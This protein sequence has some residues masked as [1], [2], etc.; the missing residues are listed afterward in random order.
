MKLKSKK[1]IL[2][3]LLLSFLLSFTVSAGLIVFNIPWNSLDYR[4]IDKLYRISLAN[5]KGPKA[6]D[7]IVYLNIDDKTYA[8][9]KT[10]YLNRGGLAKVN[11]ILAKIRPQTVFYD[12][13]FSRPSSS[14]DDTAFAASIKELGNVYLPAGFKLSEKKA[15]FRWESGVFFEKLFFDYAKKITETGKGT[16]L[17]AEWALPQH[18]SFAA[19]AFNS[20]H[21]S[22]TPD[23]DGVLRHF[24][25]I[26][27]IDSLYFPSAALSIFL[28]YNEIPFDK[29][30]I[31]W[32]ESLTIPALPE[33]YL[34]K[35]LVIP[36]DESGK[37]FVPY[38]SYWEDQKTKMI[39]VKKFLEYSEKPE[40]NDELLEYFEGSFVLISDVSVGSSDLGQ[41][42]LEENVPLISIHGALLNSLLTNN[43][44]KNWDKVAL[45]LLIFPF[46]LLIGLSTIT[47]SAIPM[48]LAGIL[49]ISACLLFGYYEMTNFILF[50]AI[51]GSGALFL[52]FIGTIVIQQIIVSKDQ[53]FIKNAF[54]KY[55][56]RKVV[57][58]LLDNPELLK[59]GG[60]ERVLSIL[61]ADIANF[62]SIS[63]TMQ[64]TELVSL[65]NEYL[66][67]MTD[68]ILSEGGTIDKYIGD[69]IL[70]E[71]GV[72]LKMD[73][74]AFA[75]VRT[76][77]M[78]QKRVNELYDG[79]REKNLPQVR[80]RIGINTGKVT[81]GNMG[82]NQVF[83]YTVIGDPVNLASRLESVNKR[84]RTQILISE[85]TLK[86]LPPDVFRTRLVDIIKV[87]GKTLA[88]KIYEVYGFA[89]EALTEED[90]NYYKAYEKGFG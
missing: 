37:A 6:S 62:T 46:G 13:I 3:I 79:S 83:D 29:I 64:S 88:V 76:A 86:E 77:L 85:F 36:I 10:N 61:F 15:L 25:L 53:A 40:Y 35:D 87:K 58:Q 66:T 11:N 90:D 80:C 54:S 59:L 38:Y 68:I 27:K 73:N 55:V 22:V 48:Y 19:N 18:D 43:F 52:I 71:F 84:Y 17:Y 12:I 49:I 28:D 24:P 2:R 50:P 75:A 67:N 23:E 81:V 89:S 82:S 56:P 7:R 26:I 20:G 70:A 47:R 21:I 30:K 4:G 69:A 78:M 60:E 5:N 45:A 74:H 51:T 1:L 42:T 14:K 33:S 34:E 41:T 63:E 39:S 44:Y 31:K 72:P 16:P 8:D 32:G 65:L 57:D 9:F